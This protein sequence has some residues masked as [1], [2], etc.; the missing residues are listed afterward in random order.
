[1]TKIKMETGEEIL[2]IIWDAVFNKRGVISLASE[3]QSRE[4]GVAIDSIP[5]RHK[6]PDG[7]PSTQSM[8]L[9]DDDG[10]IIPM[11]VQGALAMY[12]HWE[13]AKDKIS[14]LKKHF[15]TAIGPWEPH[16][17]YDGKPTMEI[18]GSEWMSFHTAK[19]VKN[20]NVEVDAS[21][22][23]M[24]ETFP[25]NVFLSPP[26]EIPNEPFFI[27]A[28]QDED[29][30]DNP[31]LY[32]NAAENLKPKECL[33]KAFHLSINYITFLCNPE[34]NNFLDNLDNS[35]LLGHNEPFNTLAFAIQAKASIPEAEALQPYLAWRPLKVIQRT[36]KNTTQLAHQHLQTPI[37]DHTKPWFPWLNCPCLHKTVATDTMFT[38]IKAIGGHHCA[39]VYW[40]FLSHYIN[41][42]GMHTE[43]DRPQ[44]LD[45][46][47]HEEGI[48]P[49]LQSDNS[50][51]QH[52][53]TG[54]LKHMRDWLCQPEFTTPHNP[55]Q[56]PAKMRAIK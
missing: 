29:G 16:R 42:Y 38:N 54:W 56:N 15:V 18:M 22:P 1:M 49:I 9:L 41:V 28:L 39:Q 21:P 14:K 10:T 13:P 51:M 55:Q 8:Y 52:W 37:H 12:Q 7:T 43:S 32:V 47:A 53:G 25:H 48:P 17:Y 45:D 36:L 33:G 26:S 11:E 24:Q 50:K 46:F 35:E 6:H 5:T 40:G 3:Y 4:F 2:W 20:T 19:E 44:T 30:D 23:I 34:V 27:D 31:P